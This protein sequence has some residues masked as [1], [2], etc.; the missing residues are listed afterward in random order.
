MREP[1]R[2]GPGDTT[3]RATDRRR[4]RAARGRAHGELPTARAPR[5]RGPRSPRACAPSARRWRS[6]RE[7]M[8]VE[9]V[10]LAYGENWVV[11]DVSLPVRQGEVLALIGASGSGKTTLLRSLNRLTEVT[12][13]AARAGRITLDGAGDPRARGQ[14]P[15]PARVDGLPAA[16]PVP[17]EHLRQRRL[18]PGRAESR[19]ADGGGGAAPSSSTPSTTR[20]AGPGCTRRSPATWTARP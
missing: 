1:S 13:G 18:R 9:S 12:A 3:S 11:R 17:D 19:R 20:C 5:P 10:W 4:A 16:Q 2:D 15:A 8:R 14:R 6:V 7:R